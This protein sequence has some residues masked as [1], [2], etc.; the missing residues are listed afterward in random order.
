MRKSIPILMKF[1]P[2]FLLSI[3]IHDDKGQANDCQSHKLQVNCMFFSRRNFSHPISWFF[4]YSFGAAFSM[5]KLNMPDWAGG[6]L[7][8]VNCHPVEISSRL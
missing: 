2:G 4:N 6:G 7:E 1:L 3:A 8:I 5:E